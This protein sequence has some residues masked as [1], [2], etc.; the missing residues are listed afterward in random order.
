MP[1]PAALP[2][3]S[4]DAL[5]LGNT[6]VAVSSGEALAAPLQLL[7]AEG[8]PPLLLEISAEAEELHAALIV[9]TS[10]L[11][12]AVL[13]PVQPS[14]P[15]LRET[16][17]LYEAR[18]AV[19]VKCEVGEGGALRDSEAEA[20]AVGELEALRD[21]EAEGSGDVD[22]RGEGEEEAL[23]EE[24]GEDF[25]ER[26]AKDADPDGVAALVSE[27]D[28]VGAPGEA[29]THELPDPPPT[30]LAVP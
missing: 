3:A 28:A 21:S 22:T 5:A 14:P 24:E 7:A 17:P 11:P 23:M 12:D 1:L 15:P 26:D 25:A 9:P 16:V 27:E 29:D 13:L 30:A 8:D 2:L 20:R 18:P 6:P 10:A 19:P 4:K